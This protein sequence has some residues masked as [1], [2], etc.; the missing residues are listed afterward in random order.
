MPYVRRSEGV[1]WGEYLHVIAG[2]GMFKLGRS[3]DPKRRLKDIRHQA[4]WLQLH[5]AAVFAGCGHLEA[6][7]HKALRETFQQ[8]GREWYRA[9]SEHAAVARVSEVLARIMEA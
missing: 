9:D 7:C 1:A 6:A 5:L 3:C 4:P 8:V 2:A